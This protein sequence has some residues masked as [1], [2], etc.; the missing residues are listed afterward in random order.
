MTV[1]HVIKLWQYHIVKV[2]KKNSVPRK[3]SDFEREGGCDTGDELFGHVT[4]HENSIKGN[5][6]NLFSPI[7][8]KSKISKKGNL[9]NVY[10]GHV[11]RV[12]TPVYN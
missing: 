2:K 7:L 3:H 6:C 1:K 12:Y 9:C 10:T 4:L 11:I 5:L 8:I